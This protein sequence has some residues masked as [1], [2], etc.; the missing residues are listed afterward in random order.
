M[1]SHTF[2]RISLVF[3]KG[4]LLDKDVKFEPHIKFEPRIKGVH[5]PHA[6]FVPSN[7]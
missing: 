6:M 3:M 2:E 1:K 5:L 7:E 4:R